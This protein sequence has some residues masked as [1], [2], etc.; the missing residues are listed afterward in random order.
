MNLNLSKILL[1]FL[2]L[3]IKKITSVSD[4][5]END[6][7]AISK[8]PAGCHPGVGDVVGLKYKPGDKTTLAYCNGDALKGG[9][10]C[11]EWDED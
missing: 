11:S 7:N 6:I 4:L 9:N 8:N 10:C 1:I 3:T 2:I 5:G